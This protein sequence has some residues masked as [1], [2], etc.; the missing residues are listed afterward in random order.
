MYTALHLLIVLFS[1]AILNKY[2]QD[3]SHNHS[4]DERGGTGK[5]KSSV[6]LKL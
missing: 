4:R 6:D 2:F 5:R 1:L 3:Q